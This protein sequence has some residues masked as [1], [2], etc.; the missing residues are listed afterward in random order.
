MIINELIM[1]QDSHFT[2]VQ[3]SMLTKQRIVTKIGRVEMIGND[4][5]RFI[6]KDNVIN[7]CIVDKAELKLIIE[8]FN[9]HYYCLANVTSYSINSEEGKIFFLHL[10]FFYNLQRWGKIPVI[11]SDEIR[12]S[13]E[14]KYIKGRKKLEEVLKENFKISDGVNSYFSYTSGKYY[15]EPGSIDEDDDSAIF[16]L[17]ELEESIEIDKIENNDENILKKEKKETLVIYGKDF[18]IYTSIKGEKINAKLYVEK[19]GKKKQNVPMMRLAEGSLEFFEHNFV[20][21][22]KVKE[23][24]ENTKGYLDLWNQYAEQEGRLLLEEVRKIGIIS[25]N[26]SAATFDSEG[27]HLPYSGLSKEAKELIGSDKY[28]FFSDEIPI[29]LANDEMTWSDYRSLSRAANKNK[30]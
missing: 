11:I 22:E 19:I 3:C 28:L 9:K 2:D 6:T 29:Y 27:I 5:F 20:L 17:E 23:T 10:A 25:V 26:R 13:I 21:S 18:C 4:K 15:F 30:Y 24:L 12:D 16:P 14:K 7:F 8:L 1:N